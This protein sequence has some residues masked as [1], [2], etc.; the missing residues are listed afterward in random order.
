MKSYNE[1]A[2]SVFERRNQYEIKQKK[3]RKILTRTLTPIFCVYL[4]ALLG[5]GVWHGDFF[6]KT[7]IQTADDP[8]IQ[9][10]KDWYCHDKEE[11]QN[12]NSG[13]TQNNNPLESQADDRCDKL[14]TII[15]NNETYVQ[16]FSI[17]SDELSLDRKI[18]NGEDFEGLYE[19]GD[20]HSE[21]Y[22]VKESSDL[23]VVKL[24]NGACIVLKRVTD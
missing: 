5:I 17:S 3:K 18:G 6:E 15:Y 1:I 8:V 2:N 4:V 24:N 23:L 9:G 7:P 14:G 11:S 16:I 22:T 19:D 20:V 13:K 21:I 10:E 12:N